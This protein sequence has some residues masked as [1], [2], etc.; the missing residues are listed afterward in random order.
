MEWYKNGME[1]V[2]R[3]D[4]HVRYDGGK[5]SLIFDK[6]SSKD[7]GRYTCN[8]WNIAGSASSTADLVIQGGCRSYLELHYKM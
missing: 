3:S 1:V 2:V 7:S 8:A 4:L 5:V 6:A